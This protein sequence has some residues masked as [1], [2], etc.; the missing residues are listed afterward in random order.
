MPKASHRKEAIAA[1]DSL[2]QQRMSRAL[3]RAADSSSEDD[4][5]EEE[6]DQLATST[7]AQLQNSRYL[8]RKKHRK[9]K[10]K[11][12]T[13]EDDLGAATGNA[14]DHNGWLTDSE[15]KQPEVSNGTY[16]FFESCFQNQG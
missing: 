13:F 5:L 8:Q 11:Q 2:V 1:A 14:D 6:L 16:V 12:Q 15:F 9:S 3:L 7:L 4:S 10:R